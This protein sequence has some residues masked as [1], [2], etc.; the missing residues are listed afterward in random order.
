MQSIPWGNATDPK[1]KVY[2]WQTKEI[3]LSHIKM[4]LQPLKVIFIIIRKL[5]LWNEKDSTDFILF[6]QIVK[7][8]FIV[9]MLIYWNELF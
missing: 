2:L 7:I 3:L 5:I 8:T 9:V 6:E 1:I 4:L